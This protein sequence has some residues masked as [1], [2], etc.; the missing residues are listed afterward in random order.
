MIKIKGLSKIYKTKH[1]EV[2][3]LRGIELNLPSVGMVF[4]LG[5]SGS[6][7]TTLLNCVSGL[8][9]PTAGVIEYDGVDINAMSQFEVDSFRNYNV[10]FVFQDYNLLDE[11]NVKKNIELVL[12]LQGEKNPEEITSNALAIVG[13]AG[14]EKR[15]LKEL[16]GGQRQRVAI[17]RAIAKDS[18]IICADE[19]TGNLDSENGEEVF[20][21]LKEISKRKLVLIVTHD[22]DSAHEYGDRVIEIVDGAISIDITVEAVDNVDNVCVI[23]DRAVDIMAIGQLNIEDDI[24]QNTENIENND[25]HINSDGEPTSAM[26]ALPQRGAT[27]TLARKKKNFSV[28]QIFQFSL[29]NMWRRGVRLTASIVLVTISLFFFGQALSQNNYDF[30]N[31]AKDL[32]ENYNL[33]ANINNRA[34]INE[35]YDSNNLPDDM[36]NYNIYQ[37]IDPAIM[38]QLTDRFGHNVAPIYCV[39]KGSSKVAVFEEET[40]EA[41]GYDIIVRDES[42]GYFAPRGYNEVVINRQEADSLLEKF[43]YPAGEYDRLIAM[44]WPYGYHYYGMQVIGVYDENDEAIK[45][46]IHRQIEPTCRARYDGIDYSESEI[47]EHINEDVLACYNN[48]KGYD[49]IVS[50]EYIDIILPAYRSDDTVQFNYSEYRESRDTVGEFNQNKALDFISFDAVKST[51]DEIYLRSG[52][53]PDKPLASD[54]AIVSLRFAKILA[55]TLLRKNH[56]EITDTEIIRIIEDGFSVPSMVKIKDNNIMNMQIVG[57]Y[58]GDKYGL[59]RFYEGPNIG[60]NSPSSLLTLPLILSDEYLNLSQITQVMIP[61]SA[62]VNFEGLEDSDALVQMVHDNA[63]ILDS[64]YLFDYE[65]FI[66]KTEISNRYVE[67]LFIMILVIG[68]VLSFV[69]ILS[70]IWAVISD[71]KRKIGVLRAQGMNIYSIVA[72]YILEALVLAIISSVVAMI[73]V[74]IFANGLTL[75]T[76]V[77]CALELSVFY[78]GAPEA[79]AML[80]VGVGIAVVGSIIPIV[81]NSRK[82]PIDLMKDKK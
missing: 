10:G 14:Y 32:H 31:V 47:I 16:S 82:S 70:Y 9:K 59:L 65:S 81:L 36:W 24:E 76:G 27:N 53:S 62:V 77:F 44:T 2:N 42:L 74:A 8:D 48:I 34:L 79:L 72:I 28:K 41:M 49:L 38:S 3:A 4:L 11:Y 80:G 30:V 46:E 5:K 23:D 68:I 78:F 55:S 60:G 43:K 50:Q 71:S 63:L 51:A 73:I 1:V 13:L 40:F 58:D 18:K 39:G 37:G 61:I 67:E 6:G 21:I 54:E 57:Y 15:K 35:N 75:T 17:A 19:P 26:S 7:K 29:T 25:N 64:L 66:T 56:E 12:D 20:K 33:L 69:T 45:G 22:R 52:R